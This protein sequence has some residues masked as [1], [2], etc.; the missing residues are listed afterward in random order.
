MLVM[1]P[2]VLVLVVSVLFVLAYGVLVAPVLDASAVLAY[3]V[4]VALVVLVELDVSAVLVF[5]VL[6][7]QLDGSASPAPFPSLDA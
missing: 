6:V 3:G 2:A 1:E 4:L 5:D 7:A